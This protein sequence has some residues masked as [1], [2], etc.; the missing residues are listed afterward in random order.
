VWLIGSI[1]AGAPIHGAGGSGRVVDAAKSGDFAAVRA[2]IAQKADV[3]VPEADGMTALHWAV[4][5]NDLP[6]VQALIRAGARVNTTNR[7]GMTP[8]LLASQ[9]G[10]PKV[11]AALLKAGGAVVGA[12]AVAIPVTEESSIE[13]IKLCL[14]R[15]VDINAFNTNGTTAVHSAVQRGAQKVVRYLAEH[16]A[17][18]DMKNKQGRTPLDIAQGVGGGAGRGNARGRGNAGPS[19]AMA[20]LLRS[21]M[22]GGAG[23]GALRQ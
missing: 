21:L 17:K 4:R 16:G 12:Y 19:Q 11:V 23:P 8:L 22:A 9:N 10:D 5:A 2:L 18:L 13:A 7:Y 15:G 6:T 3:N 20:D 14:D 1:L